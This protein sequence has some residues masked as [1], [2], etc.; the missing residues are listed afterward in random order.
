MT[1]RACMLTLFA[2]LVFTGIQVC[3][4]AEPASEATLAN[5]DVS[6]SLKARGAAFQV[7]AKGLATP[8][9]TSRVGA[10]VDHQWLWSTDYPTRTITRSTM[11]DVLGSAHRISVK[12]S[13]LSGKPELNYTLE[14]Y[15]S[16]P[17]GDIQVNVNNADGSP[18]SSGYPSDRYCRRLAPR[19]S[20][21]KGKLRTGPVGQ[22]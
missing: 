9:F 12:L 20:R 2:A 4:A 11:R 10:E 22:L 3:V 19:E 16:L 13:G 18:V 15:D 6:I 17:F 21:R 5:Q 8:V 7:S 14:V 1:K